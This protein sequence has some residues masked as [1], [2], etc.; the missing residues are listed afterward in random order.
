MKKYILPLILIIIS[1]LIGICFIYLTLK[2]TAEES[3]TQSITEIF[4]AQYHRPVNTIIIK[5]MIDTGKFSKGSYGFT[6]EMGGGLWFAAKTVNGWELA[7]AGNGIISCDAANKY[8]FPNSM[9]P[10]CIDTQNNNNLIV[11]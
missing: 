7:S 5:V 2:Y 4:S 1:L 3:T 6:D 11:R 8:N 9:V 10:Q